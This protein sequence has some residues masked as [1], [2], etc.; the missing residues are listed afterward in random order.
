MHFTFN[1]SCISKFLFKEIQFKTWQVIHFTCILEL[2][3]TKL[4]INPSYCES[5]FINVFID[6]G[7]YKK[8]YEFHIQ[9]K[10]FIL[11]INHF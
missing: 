4:S 8:D 11:G 6:C 2:L 3:D 10:Y 5:L 9:E 7:T 1:T